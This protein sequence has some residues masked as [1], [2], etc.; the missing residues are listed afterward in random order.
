MKDSFDDE[1]D[2]DI[3]N[4]SH[5]ERVSSALYDDDIDNL[6]DNINIGKINDKMNNKNVIIDKE[7]KNYILKNH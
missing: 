1:D 7:K 2:E 4:N 3:N 6:E 5:Q